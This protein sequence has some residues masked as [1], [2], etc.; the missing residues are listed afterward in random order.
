MIRARRSGY[1]LSHDGVIA[2]DG[3]SPPSLFAQLKPN[4]NEGICVTD[5]IFSLS[6]PKYRRPLPASASPAFRGP[7]AISASAPL[8][9]ATS[10]RR[11]LG[12]FSFPFLTWDTGDRRD[13]AGCIVFLRRTN[14]WTT[15]KNGR[16]KFANDVAHTVSL[17]MSAV[18]SSCCETART[19]VLVS[20]P[21][22]G[23]V[24]RFF[25]SPHLPTRC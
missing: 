8:L 24:F 21:R 7:R 17:P 3:L 4:P 16:G 1:L 14:A 12:K 23:Y 19:S 25:T 22:R 18:L 15:T 13:D 5:W 6:F 10:S 20:S 9:F 2:D 11:S